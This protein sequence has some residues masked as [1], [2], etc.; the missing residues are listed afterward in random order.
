MTDDAQTPE[1]GAPLVGNDPGYFDDPVKDA[2]V[3]MVLELGAQVWVNRER[4]ATLEAA[5]IARGALGPETVEK[6]EHDE[7]STSALVDERNEF[8][9]L[10]LRN[11]EQLANER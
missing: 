1:G 10:L 7:S 11:V 2:L 5:L 8:V 4:I 9:R 3:K 6:F